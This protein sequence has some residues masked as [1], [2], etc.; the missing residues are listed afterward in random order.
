MCAVALLR[1]A[2]VFRLCSRCYARARVWRVD[3]QSTDFVRSLE[4]SKPGF[5]MYVVVE[6]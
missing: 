6:L 3:L 5:T 2:L 4:N 1:M